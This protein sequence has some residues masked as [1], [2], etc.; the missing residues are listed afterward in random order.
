MKNL[1]IACLVGALVGALLTW[2]WTHRQESGAA[3]GDAEKKVETPKTADKGEVDAGLAL[4]PEKQ[5]AAGIKVVP[6]LAT[7]T[8]PTFRVSGR[9]IDGSTLSTLLAEVATAQNNLAAS[10]SEFN[11]LKLLY[12]QNQNISTRTFETAQAAFQRDTSA[13]EGARTRLWSAWGRKLAEADNVH[14]LASLLTRQDAAVIRLDLPIG[15]ELDHWPDQLKVSTLADENTT[16][17]AS[18]IGMDPAADPVTQGRGVFC[19]IKTTVPP[20]GAPMSAWIPQS[21]SPIEGILIPQSAILRHE[22]RTIAY[23]RVGEQSFKR[24]GFELRC[25]VGDGWLVEA[26]DEIKAGASLVVSGG[27]FLLSEELS[28]AG[29]GD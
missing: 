19:L 16:V 22:G 15:S 27:A 11:R 17:P 14:N 9:V 4:T 3:G 8:L 26:G 20:I 29:G 24:V 5:A 1:I 10:A 28:K 25:R 12:G 6:A 2:G 7:N 23:L 21:S 13:L 18:V